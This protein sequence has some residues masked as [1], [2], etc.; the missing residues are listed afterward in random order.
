MFTCTLV[1]VANSTN[2]HHDEL[3]LVIDVNAT[4]YKFR[5]LFC[6]SI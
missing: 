5:E 6:L 1:A 4:T 3:Q 2:T